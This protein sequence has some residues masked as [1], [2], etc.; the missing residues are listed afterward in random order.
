MADVIGIAYLHA[1]SQSVTETDRQTRDRQTDKTDRR[2]QTEGDRKT[3]IKNWIVSKV[4]G[5][6]DVVIGIAYLHAYS[7]SVKKETQRQTAQRQTRQDKTRDTETDRQDR[8][9]E[10]DRQE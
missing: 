10:T 3:G 7:Q 2:R 6:A 8:Q 4:C 9:E 1:C 5:M